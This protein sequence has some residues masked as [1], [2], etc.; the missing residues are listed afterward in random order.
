MIEHLDLGQSRESVLGEGEQTSQNVRVSSPVSILPSSRKDPFMSFARP[1]NPIE[2][3]LLDHCKRI[4]TV[5]YQQNVCHSHC[6]G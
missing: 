5:P 3:F 2:H 1:L 6:H 4:T